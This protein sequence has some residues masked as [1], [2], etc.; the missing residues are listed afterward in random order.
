MVA[1]SAKLQSDSRLNRD[2]ENSCQECHH[3]VGIFYLEHRCIFKKIFVMI[4]SCKMGISIDGVSSAD[5]NKEDHIMTTP[6]KVV[7][8]KCQARLKIAREKMVAENV[9]VKCPA[10]GT[11]LRIKRP[12]SSQDMPSKPAG[13]AAPVGGTDR[14]GRRENVSGTGQASPK[15][16]AMHPDAEMKPP[17]L[18]DQE[19]GTEIEERDTGNNTQD[20][21]DKTSGNTDYVRRYKRVKFKKKVLVDNQIMVEALDISEQGLF[22]HTGRSFETGAIINV[23]IP[24]APG[25]FDLKVKARVQHNHRGIGMGLMFID[26]D[27]SQ[28]IQLQKLIDSLDEAAQQELEGRMRVLLVG[29]S[30]TARN[31]LKSKLVLDGFYVMQATNVPEV[32]KILQHERPDAIVLDWQAPE[33]NARGLFYQIKEDHQY[34]NIVMVVLS[35]LTD[36]AVQKEIIDAGADRYM[37]KMDASPVKLSQTL[38]KLI[39]EKKG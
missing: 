15:E 20:E 36:A 22:L 24:T 4:L 33:F 6:V 19:T 25:N 32:H 3:T 30:D 34:D 9:K 21:E 38:K 17:G 13:P 2:P 35:A 16:M 11:V 7:C 37:A 8:P 26:L 27:D 1:T 28:I 5:Y 18:Q 12:S 39:E 23:A 14:L 31:I 10:C 29:G